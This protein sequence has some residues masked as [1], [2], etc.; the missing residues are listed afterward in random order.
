MLNLTNPIQF[1]P[2]EQSHIDNVLKPLG[3][4][5]WD[6]RDKKTKAIKGRIS[7]HNLLH[8]GCRCAYCEAIL[9]R[10]GVHIEHIAPKGIHGEFCYEA[11]NLVMSCSVCN[12]FAN[13]GK[14]DTIVPPKNA[15]YSNNTFS[16]IH[17]YFDDP[18]AHLYFIDNDKTILDLPSC[19]P[20]GLKLIEIMHWDEDFAYYAR[21]ATAALR[22]VPL[23]ISNL[24]S[25]IS[26]YK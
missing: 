18:N 16:I 26:I 10:G 5:G 19:S 7:R 9:Q 8:Q 4:S 24:I 17:P 13:K 12:A 1:T 22:S 2:F 11:S 25:E 21:C 6:Q 14:T 23:P 15:A 3:K 20:K